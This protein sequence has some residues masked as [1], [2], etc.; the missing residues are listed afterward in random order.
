MLVATAL[1]WYARNRDL[2]GLVD[3][4]GD[5][6]EA[7]DHWNRARDDIIDGLPSAHFMTPD[8]RRRSERQLQVAAAA[9]ATSLT[10]AVGAIEAVSATAPW[11]RGVTVARDRYLR[12]AQGWI[13][14]LDQLPP[15]PAA[16][17]SEPPP[18]L[19]RLR[20]TAEQAF[21]RATPPITLYGLQGRIGD[22]FVD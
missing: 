22:L 3:A 7:I 16:V 19:R 20:T 13:D 5:A 18:R 12:Y 1:D 4:T 15:D 21:R 6:A 14:Y 2:R 10:D 11:Q 17:Q 8:I 9:T